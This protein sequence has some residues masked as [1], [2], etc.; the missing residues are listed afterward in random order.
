MKIHF[1]KFLRK[2]A[3]FILAPFLFLGC[4]TDNGKIGEGTIIGL[5]LE[6]TAIEMPIISFSQKVDS[7]IVALKYSN[8]A[9]LGGY[10]G[11]RI[12]GT[13]EYDF[14]GSSEASI[15]T[16][17]VP[18]QL[19]MDF[20]DNPIVDSVKMY[21]RFNGQY[22]DTTKTI[23][24]EVLEITESLSRD[25]NYFSSFKPVTGLKVGELL[26]YAPRPKSRVSNGSAQISPSVII[27]LDKNYF[28][29][30]IAAIANGN[31][32]ELGDFDSF[33]EYMKGFQIKAVKGDG[34]MLYFNLSNAT[35]R[36]VL[37][38]H[39]DN[40]TTEAI[41]NFAQDKS[42][43]PISFSIFSQDYSNSV[44][45]I[46]NPDSVSPGEMTTYVQAM[47]GLATVFKIPDVLTA[48]PEGSIVNRAF[49]EI[50]IQRGIMS[51]LPPAGAMEIRLMTSK[52]PSSTIR[53]FFFDNRQTGDG[54]LRLGDLRNN[55]YIF[56]ITEH[57]FEV[58]NSGN[59]PNLAIVPVSKGTTATRTIL[60][61]GNDPLD[62][63]KLIVYY[64]KP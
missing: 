51:G 24:L 3:I 56:E 8:Q 4:E 10:I 27:P 30:N 43:I 23:N 39:N 6:A 46:S 12:V 13:M 34:S 38:Y 45:G 52:G 16:Q 61:G 9:S 36:I 49:M 32:T 21:L 14:V 54:S 7:V 35:S 25:S 1:G 11:T 63:I 47:G 50:P 19:N 59:N 2:R 53:D 33:I 28:Q 18:T 57:I 58:I 55:R 31:S 17:I 37:S 41:L 22:G 42:S 5:P 29:T 60:K 44:S 48:L 15:V 64:T 62:P 26:N 20:G 40:D